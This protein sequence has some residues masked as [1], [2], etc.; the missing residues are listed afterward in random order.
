M[1]CS[2]ER[3][4]HGDGRTYLSEQDR[5]GA[6][7]GWLGRLS[8]IAVSSEPPRIMREDKKDRSAS[9]FQQISLPGRGIRSQ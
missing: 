8:T 1:D 6:G 5:G 3:Q 4:S 2:T 7:R 9:R